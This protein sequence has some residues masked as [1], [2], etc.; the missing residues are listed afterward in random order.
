MFDHTV[1]HLARK[2]NKRGQMVETLVKFSPYKCVVAGRPP[3]KY[4]LRDGVVRDAQDRVV[5]PK[6]L[7]PDVLQVFKNLTEE[8]K[9]HYGKVA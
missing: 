9:K 2:K 8:G 7:P 5:D 1:H 6:N 3:L 4:F